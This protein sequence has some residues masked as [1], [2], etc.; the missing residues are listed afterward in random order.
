[1]LDGNDTPE[2]PTIP[3]IPAP[4]KRFYTEAEIALVWKKAYALGKR[5]GVL[6]EA[7]CETVHTPDNPY[8]FPV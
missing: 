5:D 6:Q 2:W 3:E 8:E 1:M 4:Q 7:S